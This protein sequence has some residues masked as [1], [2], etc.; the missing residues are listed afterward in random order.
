LA[1]VLGVARKRGGIG[2][3][4][5]ILA[6]LRFCFFTAIQRI[7]PYGQNVRPQEN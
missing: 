4:L 7:T 3:R 6:G 2:L 1:A 5:L